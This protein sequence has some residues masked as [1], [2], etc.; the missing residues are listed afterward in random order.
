MRILIAII[1]TFLILSCKSKNV[2]L[3]DYGKL[4]TR[5]ICSSENYENANMILRI[6]DAEFKFSIQEFENKMTDRNYGEYND[7]LANIKR[8]QKNNSSIYLIQ[9]ENGYITKSADTICPIN[10][11]GTSITLDELFIEGKFYL[12]SP[13]EIKCVEH[14]GWMPNYQGTIYSEW[15]MDGKI[16]K[17]I[18]LG[19]VN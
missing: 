8:L 15:I 10:S 2:L 18:E 1:L 13:K 7:E 17:R 5:F 3:T 4:D 16:I 6:N 11:Y 19:Y 14:K 9:M 12:K